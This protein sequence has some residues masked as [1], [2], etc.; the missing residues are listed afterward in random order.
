MEPA[1]GRSPHQMCQSS[2]HG[3]HLIGD[4]SAKGLYRDLLAD[5]LNIV[6]SLIATAKASLLDSTIPSMSFIFKTL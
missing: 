4:A 1:E 6:S 3:L 2:S 5:A